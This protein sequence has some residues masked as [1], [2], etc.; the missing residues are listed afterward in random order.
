M[1]NLKLRGYR[2]YIRVIF[3]KRFEF[4]EMGM[5]ALDSRVSGLIRVTP[6]TLSE[7]KPCWNDTLVIGGAWVSALG[8]HIVEWGMYLLVRDAGF[9]DSELTG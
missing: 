5:K 9:W 2:G 1:E 8:L 7:T 6:Y 4:K 3:F